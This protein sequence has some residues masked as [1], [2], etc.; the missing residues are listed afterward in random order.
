M[1]YILVFLNIA[2]CF[3]YALQATSST[4]FRR[5]IDIICA[6]LWGLCAVLNTHTYI[7]R[8]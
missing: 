7:I 3:M 2:C 4:G 1:G 6:M 8:R 5:T